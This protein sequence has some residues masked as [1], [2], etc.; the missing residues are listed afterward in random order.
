MN[1]NIENSPAENRILRHSQPSRK[2][3]KLDNYANSSI[4]EIEAH[5]D[6]YLGQIELV[7]H[8]LISDLVHIDILYIPPSSQRNFI[9]FVTSWMSDLPMNVPEELENWKYA[10]VMVTLSSTWK[11]EEKD[12]KDEK[13]Y[14]VIRMLKTIARL[15]HRYNTWLGYGHTIPNGDPAQPY[16][17][18]N[19]TGVMLS[20]PY[21]VNPDFFELKVNSDKTIFFYSM[22]PLYSEEME[23]KLKYGVDPHEDLFAQSDIVENLVDVNRPNVAL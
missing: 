15:P 2:I 11:V 22:A 3:P 17:G 8:E 23:I 20:S 16:P 13:N 7:W 21:S 9:T 1:D 5:V 12:F 14:W 19:F 4:S 10:E 6:K 18:T